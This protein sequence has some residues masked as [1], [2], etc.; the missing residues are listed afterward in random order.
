[1]QARYEE[2]ARDFIHPV[3]VGGVVQ[4]GRPLTPG[5]LDVFGALRP[6]DVEVDRAIIDRLHETG[7]L[8]A[9]LRS[10][11]WPARGLAALMMAAHNLVASTDP[12]LDRWGGRGA[13][14]KMLEWADW[15][16]DRAGAPQ[17]RGEAL[18][19]H[20]FL[21]RF[22]DLRR[23]DVT[24]RNWAFTHRYLGRPVPDGF[25]TRP[26]WVQITKEQP[27]VLQ[28]WDVLDGDFD[29]ATRRRRLLHRSPV[30]SLLRTDLE[31]DL[32]FSGSILAVLSDDLVR[33]GVARELV[34]QGRS[35]MAPLGR[36]LRRL[37][38]VDPP[39]S[40]LYYGLALIYEMH[41]IGILDTRP[42][43][44]PDL[45]RPTTQD[46]AFFC[47][48]L[49]AMAGAPDELEGLLDLDH[50]DL[51]RVRGRAAHLDAQLEPELVRHA[52]AV[53][54]RATPPRL[55][56]ERG[57]AAVAGVQPTSGR[58]PATDEPLLVPRR[59][60]GDKVPL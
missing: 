39:T 19:R 5:M 31:S 26:R 43:R 47:A 18:A 48:V 2:F 16:L 21:S 20:G 3:L 30:T 25:F 46:E 56:H 42:G 1:M 59:E 22:L 35:T 41:V 29:A 7:S 27:G 4:V 57:V 33:N 8:L 53:V 14:S 13:V 23:E 51:E 40:F 60:S 34:A 52:I 50:S 10:L 6:V 37:A 58:P 28:L 49:P 36:A 12:S 17:T 55:D 45:A 9:P 11:P 24:A 44:E 32:R 38:A 15:F 54:E